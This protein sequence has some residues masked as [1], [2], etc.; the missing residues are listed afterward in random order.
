MREMRLEKINKLFG[1]RFIAGESYK[2]FFN[3]IYTIE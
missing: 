2:P 3:V 1:D